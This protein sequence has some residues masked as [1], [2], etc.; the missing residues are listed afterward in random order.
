MFKLA[1]YSTTRQPK[2]HK[3]ARQPAYHP[4]VFSRGSALL[5]RCP[6]S[7]RGGCEGFRRATLHDMRMDLTMALAR[8]QE[9]VAQVARVTEERDELRRELEER[10][11]DDEEWQQTGGGHEVQHIELR[12]A[13][14][15]HH[16]SAKQGVQRLS[17]Q[18][19]QNGK[20]TNTFR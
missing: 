18:R 6:E 11:R 2:C 12:R 19:R 4:S 20:R 1:Q 3:L 17:D 13:T 5:K 9:L 15:S 8:S 16:L 7:T 10:R 14:L